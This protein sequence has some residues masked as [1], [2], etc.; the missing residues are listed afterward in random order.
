[1]QTGPQKEFRLEIY[2]VFSQLLDIEWNLCK[3]ACIIDASMINSILFIQLW[4]FSRKIGCAQMSTLSFSW[5]QLKTNI[6][7]PEK[8]NGCM[9]ILWI[10]I[11]ELSFTQ[12]HEWGIYVLFHSTNQLMESNE[13]RPLG[14][15]DSL[16]SVR[17][18]FIQILGTLIDLFFHQ[19]PGMFHA[20]QGQHNECHSHA[21]YSTKGWVWNVNTQIELKLC[22]FPWL[23]EL[24][25]L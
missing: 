8:C 25:T 1:M 5:A 14:Q 20:N 12:I 2:C 11:W 6:S 10:W 13:D 17:K 19:I 23:P 24:S 18:S 16:S 4:K 22:E 15:M 9:F 21:S 3:L 7:F